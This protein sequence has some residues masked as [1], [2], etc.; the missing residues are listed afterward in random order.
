MG[1]SKQEK[2][3]RNRICAHLNIQEHEY[4]P[5]IYDLYTNKYMSAQEIADHIQQNTGENITATIVPKTTA[6]ARPSQL[7]PGLIL[8][9]NLRLPNRDPIV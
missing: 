2:T 9:E 5:H 3:R 4:K 8:G 1:L 7:L 6:P